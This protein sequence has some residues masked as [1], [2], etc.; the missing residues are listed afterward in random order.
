[1]KKNVSLSDDIGQVAITHHLS[2]VASSMSKNTDWMCSDKPGPKISS[3]DTWWVKKKI[4]D[5]IKKVN[6]PKQTGRHTP[7]AKKIIINK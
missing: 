1:M 3:V 4:R 2:T 5:K 6:K 7:F